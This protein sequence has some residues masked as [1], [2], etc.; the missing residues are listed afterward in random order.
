MFLWRYKKYSSWIFLLSRDMYVDW[1]GSLL[2]IYGKIL[3][4]QEHT[5][6]VVVE[7]LHSVVVICRAMRKGLQVIYKLQ[8]PKISDYLVHLVSRITASSVF[9]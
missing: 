5:L 2:F 1:S 7:A 8:N 9:H 4:F 3:A 6:F